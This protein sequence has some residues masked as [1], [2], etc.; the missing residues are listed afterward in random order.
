MGCCKLGAPS[1]RRSEVYPLFARP[2][3]RALLVRAGAGEADTAVLR[4]IVA[5]EWEQF[6]RV[7][8]MFGRASC[9]D[10]LQSFFVYRLA[11][12][13]AFPRA[14]LPYILDDLRS[15]EAGGRNL[16]EEKYA[17]MM[18]ATDPER[19][20]ATW[21]ARLEA[22]SPVRAAV[23]GEIADLV[24]ARL[25]EASRDLSVTSGH[26]RGTVSEPGRVSALDYYLAEAAGYR[27]RT[28]FAL[29]DGLLRQERG[30]MNAI[31]DTYRY[32]VG[33]LTALEATA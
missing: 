21:A 22:P 2:G 3:V 8:G 24:R 23:L 17:R 15:A 25:E 9:Q 26:A 7:E 33:L 11:Q 13:L 32:T 1:G 18:E 6:D 10:D 14:A 31:E 30:R 27:L 4:E 19:Y 12:H 20:A 5:L 16:V 29:R 28:L